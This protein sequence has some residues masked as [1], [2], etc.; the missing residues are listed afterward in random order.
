MLARMRLPTLSFVAA[1]LALAACGDDGGSTPVDSGG[2]IDVATQDAAAIDAP[3][4]GTFTL[5]STAY[6]DGTTI[7]PAQ[8]CAQRGGMNLSPPLVWSNA[9]TGTMSFAIVF[10][11]LTN[12]L[13]HSAIYDIPASV[14]MLPG[15]VDK[16]YAP[17]DV[18][19][20]HHPAAYNN[21]RGY[22]GPC[23]GSAHMYQHKI[24][25]LATATPPNTTMATTAEDLVP[26]L[27]TNLGTATL[28]GTFTPP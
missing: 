20:A 16:V 14:T 3:P 15:D 27:A 17:P 4:T 1:T 7:P 2:S 18:P 11:D 26:N 6:A 19:G 10:T 12:G 9:P 13:V 22:A 8:A 21:A 28:T 5:T 24:Y 23:P 25:A